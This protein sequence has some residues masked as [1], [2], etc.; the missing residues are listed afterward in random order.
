MAS[1]Q[2]R[3]NGKWRARYRDEQGKEH[4][5]H[6]D[7]KIDA[8]DW[9]DGVT[10]A[11]RSGTYVDPA[12]TK[13]SLGSFFA[14]WSTRQ[15]WAA[16]TQVAM[17]LAVRRCSFVDVELGKLRRSHFETWIKTMSIEG[18][19]PSTIKTR[20][21]NVRSVVKAAVRDKLLG[22][23]PSDGLTLPRTRRAEHAMEIPSPET[24]GRILE[25][26]EDWF[27]PYIALC[28]FTGLR[29]AEASGVQLGDINFLRRE[30][31]L[32]RQIQRPI[33]G[34]VSITPPKYGS[35]RIVFMPDRLLKMIA[36]HAEHIGVRGDE[37]WLFVGDEGLPPHP[38]TIAYWWRKTLKVADVAPVHL[39]SLRHFYASG[40]IAAGCDVVT[41]QRALGHA[42]AT[43]TLDTYSHLWPTAADRT[44]SAAGDLMDSVFT[45]PAD[46][47]RT[48]SL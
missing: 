8:Q 2:K 18:L 40:L 21:N 16:G 19:A 34:R 3:P 30:L 6:F 37:R 4:A 24:V 5:S 26:A 20:V 47:L 12:K 27:R 45:A 44:R 48:D 15:V 31:H 41:V 35:E 9:L 38:N 7:R 23:D 22:S 1:I 13:V 28:A 46:S 33:E 36:W 29:L 39:H 17:E 42:K 10:V 14:D 43:T 11:V 25:A 32:A